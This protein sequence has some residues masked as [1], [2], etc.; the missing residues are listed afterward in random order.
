MHPV[1]RVNRPVDD[2]LFRS[3]SYHHGMDVQSTRH[4]P[5]NTIVITDGSVHL[6]PDRQQQRIVDAVNFLCA[7]RLLYLDKLLQSLCTG[8][9]YTNSSPLVET[10]ANHARANPDIVKLVFGFNPLSVPSNTG[11]VGELL[12][13]LGLKSEQVKHTA[14]YAKPKIQRQRVYRL[15]SAQLQDWLVSAEHNPQHPARVL[16]LR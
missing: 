1:N 3:V 7:C 9:E 14:R 6:H 4:L 8:E 5:A 11:I 13:A 16:Q 2:S 15:H 10:V 12:Q